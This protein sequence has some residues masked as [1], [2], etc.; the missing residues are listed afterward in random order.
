M[1]KKLIQLLQL[2][3]L[4][5]KSGVLQPLVLLMK[6]STVAIDTINETVAADTKDNY[7]G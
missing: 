3:A 7:Y 2:S 1:L 5:K 4:L 6:S